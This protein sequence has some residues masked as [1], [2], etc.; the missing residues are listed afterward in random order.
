MKQLL[1]I[2][3]NH[4]KESILAPLFK[5]IEAL[6][7]LSIPLI[8][9]D[10][11]NNGIPNKDK[12]YVITH[13]ILMIVLGLIGLICS[14]VAQY[15]AAKAAVE[16]CSNVRYKMFNKVQSL[17][18]SQIDK[19]GT[20][21]LVTRMT[22]DINQMQNGINMF[23][24]L[25]L[26]SPFVVLGATVLAFTIN[27]KGALIF[28]VAIPVLAVI[29]FMIMI[30]TIPGYEKV[31]YF[32]DRLT[33][34]TR[35]NLTGVRV[36]RAFGRED[37]EVA[38]FK[39]ADERLLESQLKVGSISVLMDPLTFIVINVAIVAIL[40]VGNVEVALGSIT[41]G[42]VV[43]LV[44]YMNQILVELIKIANL[45][46]QLTKADACG[47]RVQKVLDMQPDLEFGKNGLEDES[48][49]AV[50]FSHVSLAYFGSN[51]DSLEDISF[52]VKKGQTV[53]II[54][55]TGSGKTS[56]VEL[57]PRYYE[58]SEGSV[59]IFGKNIKDYDKRAL[60]KS[61]SCVMQKSLLFSGTINYL[62]VFIIFSEIFEA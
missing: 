7:D 29:I 42:A 6:F 9:A 13:C 10:I 59:K 12:N 43:A 15:F 52:K 47:V 11:I 39:Q 54:G 23:L 40:Y 1:G 49:I 56:L 61:V 5:M 24:R 18:F 45:I 17:G 3:E 34:I 38:S 62:F 21:T 27:I 28:V 55:G 26:R 31:Q 25:F 41:A 4:K 46:I 33:G 50:D 8:M 37:S 60:R 30:M 22:S 48:D 57:I 36:V 58:A 35:E 19:M 16:S 44:N 14:I 20:S 2:L 32:L 53:G 51:E